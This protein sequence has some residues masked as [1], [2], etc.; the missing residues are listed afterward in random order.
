MKKDKKWFLGKYNL[1][2]ASYIR[3]N[4]D[5]S[6]IPES[7]DA[8]RDASISFEGDDDV[9]QL[10]TRLAKKLYLFMIDTGRA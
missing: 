3:Y 6:F 4:Q 2:R 1:N 9:L 8:V 10:S 7:E 5:T